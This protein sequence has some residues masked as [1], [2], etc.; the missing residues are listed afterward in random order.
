MALVPDVLV[1]RDVGDGQRN[2]F[3]NL[4]AKPPGCATGCPVPDLLGGRQP[5]GR[6][7]QRK[8]RLSEEDSSSR[9]RGS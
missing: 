1:L 2:R 5:N 3:V 8:A 6:L 4:K 7:W 9:M